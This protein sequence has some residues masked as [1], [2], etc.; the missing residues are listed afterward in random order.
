[1]VPEVLIEPLKRHL[2]E[3]RT[4]HQPTWPAGLGAVPVPDAIAG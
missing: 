2:H 3:A 1:M 4:H